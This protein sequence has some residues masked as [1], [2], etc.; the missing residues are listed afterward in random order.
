MARALEIPLYHLFYED[1]EPPV[2]KGR[3]MIASGPS[4]ESWLR[5]VHWEGK[6]EASTM[7]AAISNDTQCLIAAAS[8]TGRCNTI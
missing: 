6:L 5:E 7:Q 1:E 2:L 4:S 3:A 8:S